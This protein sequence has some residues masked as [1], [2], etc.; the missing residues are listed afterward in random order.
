MIVLTNLAFTWPIVGCGPGVVHVVQPDSMA[1]L[2][3]TNAQVSAEARRSAHLMGQWVSGRSSDKVG[4][5]E[6]SKLPEPYTQDDEGGVWPSEYHLGYAALRL[7]R[8][9]YA[10]AHPAYRVLDDGNLVEVVDEAGGNVGLIEDFDKD[11]L[12]DIADVEARALF[13]VVPRG[14]THRSA[15]NNKVDW[16]LRVINTAMLGVPKFKLGTG[17]GGEIGVR[18]AE[19]AAPWKIAWQT[20]DPGAVEYRWL[21][22]GAE[23]QTAEAY[24][25]AYLAKRWRE[26]TLREISRLGRAL[27]EVVERLVQ[28]RE[29]LGRTRAATEMPVLPGKTLT[30]YLRS[31]ALWSAHDDDTARLLPVMREPPPAPARPDPRL[32]ADTKGGSSGAGSS[33]KMYPGATQVDG[34]VVPPHPSAPEAYTLDGRFGN[35][36]W[37]YF[38]GYSA[39][40]VI[41]YHYQARYQGLGELVFKNHVSVG[42]IVKEAGGEPKLLHW[43][44]ADLRP[45][46]THVRFREPV[47]YVF[48]IKPEGPKH[49]VKGKEKL[50]QYIGVLNVGMVGKPRV[51]VPGP[52]YEGELWIRFKR[53]TRLWAVKWHSAAPGLLLY[54]W[55]K[56]EVAESG[57]D[58]ATLEE[59]WRQAIQDDRWRDISEKEMAADAEELFLTVDMLVGLRETLGHFR[60]VV[61]LPIQGVGLAAEAVLSARLWN[62]MDAAPRV[63]PIVRVPAPVKQPAVPPKAPPP[64]NA[65]SLGS[66]I[67]HPRPTP[68]RPVAPGKTLSGPKTVSPN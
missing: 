49:F 61:T 18:F 30:E 31:V 27:H 65:P 32:M 43:S 53:G 36:P 66:D 39:H 3:I 38:M 64:V 23:Q 2:Q 46:I 17:Y 62:Q 33:P 55:I 4:I 11:R 47:H 54:R 45:D 50:A 6:D 52:K 8:E 44:E 59:E 51:F 56:P 34:P 9:H 25:D 21:V 24:G 7:I 42:K 28:A 35:M 13:E 48:E 37:Q 15:A 68:A 22:L 29:E 16:H 19:G 58:M 40:R 12:I 26:P 60:N 5:L 14:Q 67:H 41:A 20:T 63:V 10:A 1:F 57:K